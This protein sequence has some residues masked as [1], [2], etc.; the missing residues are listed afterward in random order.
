MRIVPIFETQSLYSF[1]YEGSSS[2]IFEQLFDNWNDPFY[3]EQF[4]TDHEGDLNKGF[5]GS[6][7]IEE[8]ALYTRQEAQRLERLLYQT[9]FERRL[10]TIFRPLSEIEYGT[11]EGFPKQ[12]AYGPRT[13]SWLRIYA[14]KIDDDVFV[15]T[16]GAIKLTQKMSERD[17]TNAELKQLR[18]CVQFFEAQQIIDLEGFM[19]LAAE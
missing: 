11:N 2:N 6:I 15:V 16:G 1:H 4:F 17:H 8:A 10:R 14:L 18:R 12:K 13:L 7:T 19:E 5:Y 3:L 9:V